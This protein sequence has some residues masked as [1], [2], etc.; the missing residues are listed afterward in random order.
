MAR[1]LVATVPL[2]GHVHPMLPLVRTL[3]ERGH[4][5]SWYGASKFATVIEA[6]GATYVPML[7]TL[8][9]DDADIEAALPTL[10]G[11]RGL[12]R[13]KTQLREMF[14][15]PMVDQLRDLEGVADE[16]APDAIIADSAHLGAA[17][18][19]EK[20]GLPW[21]GVGISALMIPSVDTAP[22]GSALPPSRSAAHRTTNR[23]LNWLIL[24]VLFSGTNRS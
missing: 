17:L 18:L 21:A 8:D 4:H 2:T 13:V 16:L 7:A 5:V 23:F 19:S 6:A 20:R 3:V 1:L 11:R 14:I 24:R 22:F 10:R 15:S 9:W 12:G